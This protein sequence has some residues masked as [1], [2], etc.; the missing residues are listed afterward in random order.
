MKFEQKIFI[1][2]LIIGRIL[3][4]F[5]TYRI[6]WALKNEKN[7]LIKYNLLGPGSFLFLQII[8]TAILVIA[9]IYYF[10][11]KKNFY[12]QNK[13][14]YANF[15][16]YYF[17]GEYSAWSNILFDPRLILKPKYRC[18]ILN[19]QL[20]I[21]PSISIVNYFFGTI[22]NISV[23]YYNQDLLIFGFIWTII[24]LGFISFI[25]LSVIILKI[26][27]K[28]YLKEFS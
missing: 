22:N 16:K 8:V 26:N 20:I 12:P 3:D 11:N 9:A 1:T 7:P 28:E 24:I 18:H 19:F 27:Y 2:F 13:K 5:T 10:K 17:S 6:S 25:I 23:K 4:L 14:T 21:I 15:S